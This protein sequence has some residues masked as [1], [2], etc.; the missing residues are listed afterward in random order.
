MVSHI[1]AER[2]LTMVKDMEPIHASDR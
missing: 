1:T 2:A